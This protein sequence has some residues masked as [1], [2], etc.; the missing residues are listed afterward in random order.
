MFT[1]RNALT[2]VGLAMAVVAA[3][4]V[5]T[6]VQAMTS[7]AGQLDCVLS[8]A[9]ECRDVASEDEP[10]GSIFGRVVQMQELQDLGN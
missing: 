5:L 6:A 10:K 9:T 4:V 2:I 1:E 3:F 8:G 7:A